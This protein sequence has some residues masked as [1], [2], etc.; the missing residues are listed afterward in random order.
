MCR[1]VSR[2]AYTWIEFVVILA[3][4]GIAAGLIVPAIQAARERSRRIRCTS[5]LKWIGLCVH[6]YHQANKCFPPGTISAANTYPN[7][8][9]TEATTGTTGRDG[10]GWSLRIQGYDEGDPYPRRWWDFHCN[11]MYNSVYAS[12]DL[13][14]FFCPS[15]RTEI[16]LGVDTQNLPSSTWAGGGTDYGGCAGR[17]LAFDTSYRITD[18]AASPSPYVITSSAHTISDSTVAWKN[19]GIFGGVNVSNTFANIRD[20]V[21]NTIMTGEL[22]RIVQVTATGPFTASKGPYLSKDSWAVGGPASTFSTGVPNAAWPGGTVGPL[23]NNGMFGAPGSEHPGGANFGI[24]DGSVIFIQTN[25]D[26]DVFHLLG[27]MA[28]GE[29]IVVPQ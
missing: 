8:V 19:W 12:W 24:A 17:H 4:L 6:N 7:D 15:R 14:G 2:T 3:V 29:N 25:I 27:S 20:G 16:R 13:S 11:V 28:D 5:H 10:T 23:M 9:W 18:P 26:N 21:S 22:Q 1:T